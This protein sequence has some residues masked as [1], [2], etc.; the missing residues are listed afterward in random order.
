MS[1]VPPHLLAL[2]ALGRTSGL[3]V[4]VG[5]LE[6]VAL[7]VRSVVSFLNVPPLEMLTQPP[8]RHLRFTSPDHST[9]ALNPLLWLPPTCAERSTFSFSISGDSSLLSPPCRPLQPP[10][11]PLCLPKESPLRYSRGKAC[12]SEY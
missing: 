6:I 1:F 2:L 12:W 4:D 9:H 5:N 7:P 10:G 11:R 8:Y 3:V